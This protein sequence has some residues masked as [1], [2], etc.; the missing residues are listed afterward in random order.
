[1]T[2]LGRKIAALAHN[3]FEI[4]LRFDFPRIQHKNVFFIYLLICF[5][6]RAANRE[7]GVHLFKENDFLIL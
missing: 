4:I 7:F 5:L 1:M 6:A 3:P 2:D